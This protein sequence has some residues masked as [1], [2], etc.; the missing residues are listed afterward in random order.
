[1]DR[2]TTIGLVLIGLI[3]TVFTVFNQ[4][5]AEDPAQKQDAKKTAVSDKKSANQATTTDSV[6]QNSPTGAGQTSK[7]DEAKNQTS[8]MESKPA[9]Q[10]PKAVWY[11]LE[12]S[13]IKAEISNQGCPKLPNPSWRY[14]Y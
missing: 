1:M 14:E 11:T 8:A 4:P 13:A 6:A 12:N 2:N 9:V 7:K 10:A 3:L 5:D